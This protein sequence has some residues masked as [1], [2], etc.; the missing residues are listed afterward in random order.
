M[1]TPRIITIDGPSGVGKSTLARRLAETLGLPILDTGA[2]FRILAYSLGPQATEMTDE[3]L[4]TQLSGYTFRLTGAGFSSQLLCN[5]RA[6][7]DEIRTEDVALVASALATKPAIRAFLKAAQQEIGRGT[8]LVTE[9][10]DM[11]TVIF[12][13]ATRKLY[14]DATPGVRAERRARQ[15]EEAGLPMDREKIL[16][17][18]TERDHLDTNRAEAP[19][20]PA[21]DAVII[22]TDHLDINRVFEEILRHIPAN[23]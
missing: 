11:G 21:D 13:Q 18:I 10:R 5:D 12:P 8:S 16:R 19:L 3:E 6:F 23:Q 4:T 20:K 22:Q 2:M 9:G 7:G 14:L 17:Q 15:Y 1:N